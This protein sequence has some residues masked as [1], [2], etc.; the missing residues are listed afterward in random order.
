MDKFIFMERKK[1]TII[2]PMPTNPK[3]PNATY[4][5][6][7]PELTKSDKIHIYKPI[8]SGV[9]QKDKCWS[10]GFMNLAIPKS[11]RQTQPFSSIRTFSGFKSRQIIF[12][13]WRKLRPIDMQ[14]VQ[15]LH[16]S[17]ANQRC[18][19]KCQNSSPPLK[20]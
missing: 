7:S 4:R 8:Y 18:S 16:L 10:Y 11:A 3:Q 5:I 12:F 15:N 9:P 1:L 6:I 2:S 17:S 20:E 14:A 13:E 19:R